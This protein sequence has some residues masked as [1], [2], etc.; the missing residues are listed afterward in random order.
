[1]SKWDMELLQI[2]LISQERP[3]AREN[4]WG[5]TNQRKHI[6]TS[7]LSFRDVELKNGR[8]MIEC[9][10]RKNAFSTQNKYLWEKAVL[11]TDGSGWLHRLQLRWS[12]EFN[13]KIVDSYCVDRNHCML[14]KKK[15]RRERRCILIMK[16]KQ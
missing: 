2:F 6:K 8:E 4:I 11:Y 3:G 7:I 9:I 10:R 14:F 1:M 12:L 16:V 15:E 13:R 5:L